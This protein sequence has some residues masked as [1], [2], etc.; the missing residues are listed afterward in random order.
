MI[1][2]PPRSTLSSS[3]AASDVY[4]RQDLDDVISPREEELLSLYITGRSIKWFAVLDMLL[5]LFYVFTNFVFLCLLPL[6]LIGY[7]GARKFNRNA[8]GMYMG[9]VVLFIAI[10]VYILVFDA[11]VLLQIIFALIILVEIWILRILWS[12]WQQLRDLTEEERE[13]LIT[14]AYLH[15]QSRVM[16]IW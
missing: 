15:V 16:L 5:A 1:R 7:W 14:D 13:A 11:G 6:P 2:R 12:L 3:S 10:R 9:I 8:I 4:K